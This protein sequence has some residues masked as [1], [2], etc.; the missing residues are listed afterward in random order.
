MTLI[1]SH[2]KIAVLEPAA[3]S[4]LTAVMIAGAAFL[5]LAVLTVGIV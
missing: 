2:G 1:E 3:A 4:Y 5:L